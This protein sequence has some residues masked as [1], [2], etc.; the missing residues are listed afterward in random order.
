MADKCY[1]WD[2][3]TVE[4]PDESTGF[5]LLPKGD[6]PFTVAKFERGLHEPR[7]GGKL[8]QCKKAILTIRIDG[9][10]LGEATVTHNLY[11]H[12]SCD[13]FLCAFFASLGHRKHGEALTMDWSKVV[14]GEGWCKVIQ[15]PGKKEGMIFN[16]I[17]RF[18]DP[19]AA[20][21]AEDD[22]AF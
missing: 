11:M 5:K 16:E 3:P 6:Y 17:E 9:G 2:E 10:E 21:A 18:I 20:T 13:N 1:E 8:P 14:G 15:K 12:S 22:L 4:T 19:P 7:P